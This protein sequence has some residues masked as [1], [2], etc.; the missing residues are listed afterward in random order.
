MGQLFPAGDCHAL[1]GQ[2]LHL[3]RLALREQLSRIERET[4]G[5]GLLNE[6]VALDVAHFGRPNRGFEHFD[7]FGVNEGLLACSSKSS[8]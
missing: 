1:A 4:V 6:L 5:F 3:V 7:S 2:G 8:A